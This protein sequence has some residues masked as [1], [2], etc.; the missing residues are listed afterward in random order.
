MKKIY[1]IKTGTTFESILKEH[2]DFE[3]WIL[4]YAKSVEY[5]VIDINNNVF[6]P[7][8]E[9]CQGVIITGSHSMVTEAFS[10]SLDVDVFIKKLIK[11]KIP[12]LGICFGHQLIA[13]SLGGEVGYSPHGLE[14]GS[15]PISVNANAKDDAL[16]SNMPREFYAHVVHFQS[17]LTLP[18]NAVLIASNAVE[19]NHIYKIGACAWGVQFHPEFDEKIMKSYI[20]EVLDPSISDSLEKEL[21]SKVK[22]T[23]YS[24]QT[25]ENF[26]D[27]AKEYTS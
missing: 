14:I 5:E 21:L 1:I 7:K 9:N 6:L 3:H 11:Y 17:V 23:K 24:N 19:K 8:M 22:N 20:T 12:L 27:F 10:W 15:V 16:F 4:K 13:K 25:I 2:G 18:K 26:L